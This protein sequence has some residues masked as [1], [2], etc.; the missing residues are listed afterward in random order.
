M[1]IKISGI[2][3]ALSLLISTCS[4]Q[5]TQAE[6]ERHT[7]PN[8]PYELLLG[9]SLTDQEVTEFIASNN[10]SSAGQFQLCKNVGMALFV[11]LEQIVETIYLYLNNA[12]GFTPYQGELPFGLKFYDTLGAVEYKLQR[13]AGENAEIPE[14]GASPD[15]MHYWVDYKQYGMTVIYNCSFAD[16][17]ATI[18][19]I[20]VSKS[21]NTMNAE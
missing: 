1:L 4:A 9:K 2:F 7:R 5:S 6:P 17:D 3:A 12:E 10:C 16:E 21:S 18:Y 14:E 20:L 19:A 8:A 11:N 13:L 15:H